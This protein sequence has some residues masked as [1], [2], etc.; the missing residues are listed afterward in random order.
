MK[1]NRVSFYL[2][3]RSGSFSGFFQSRLVMNTQIV[4]PGEGTHFKKRDE[5]SHAWEPFEGQAQ[6][7]GMEL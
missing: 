2:K 5:E 7:K 6:S 3:K 4:R 1:L